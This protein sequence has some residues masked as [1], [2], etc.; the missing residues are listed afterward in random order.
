[1]PGPVAGHA[2]D[3]VVRAR[4]VNAASGRVPPPIVGHAVAVLAVLAP[5][6]PVA[7]WAAHARAVLARVAG[8]AKAWAELAGMDPEDEDEEDENEEEWEY[9]PAAGIDEGKDSS[10]AVGPGVVAEAPQSQ[11]AAAE[12]YQPP[13]EPVKEMEVKEVRRRRMERPT[14]VA[15]EALA[16]DLVAC[17]AADV[18]LLRAVA[19]WLA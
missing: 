6:V 5:R 11:I 15:D 7:A 12:F 16:A 1:M 18:P 3:V 13:P 10:A 2:A 17:D 4:V 8:V 9:D 14:P 19:R